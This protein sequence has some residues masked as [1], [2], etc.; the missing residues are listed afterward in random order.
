[1]FSYKEKIIAGYF[2][3]SQK[4]NNLQI[5]AGLRFENTKSISNAITIDSVVS[6]NYLEWLPLSAPVIHLIN[7]MK[8]HFLTVEKLHDPLFTTESF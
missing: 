1:M 5:N 3:Y 2:T 4:F 8:F 6:R 7:P